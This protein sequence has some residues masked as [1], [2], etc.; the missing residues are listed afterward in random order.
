MESRFRVIVADPPWPFNDK[1]PGPNRGAARNY[2][3]MTI[4]EIKSFSLPPVEDDSWLFLWR[5]TQ[6]QKE[7]L[8]VLDAWGYTLK[9]EIVWNKLTVHGYPW[10][11]IGRTVRMSHEVCLIGAKGRPTVNNRAV[12]S[13]FAAQAGQHSEKPEPF[14]KIVETL[15][16]GPYAELFARRRRS[17][18][19]CLGDEV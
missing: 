12:R 9:S 6:M 4:D 3:L 7:A 14:F 8:E 5:V 17:G 10:F 13:V 2:K 1:L 11:G 18:W 16:N 15:C 19:T